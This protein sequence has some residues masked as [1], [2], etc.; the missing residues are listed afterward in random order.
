MWVEKVFRFTSLSLHVHCQTLSAGPA[1]SAD[2]RH[3]PYHAE[4]TLSSAQVLKVGECLGTQ[5]YPQT[6]TAHTA[7]VTWR[8]HLPLFLLRL[9]YF[10]CRINYCGAS[11]HFFF[12]ELHLHCAVR[13]QAFFPAMSSQT[14]CGGDTGGGGE[15]SEDGGGGGGSMTIEESSVVTPGLAGDGI[16]EGAAEGG[17]EGEAEGGV[18]GDGA[19]SS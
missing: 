8:V 7:L 3:T 19:S 15:G 13:L 10:T 12:D 6:L 2:L 9:N 11:L 5:I 14:R 17:G 18:C 16:G 4:S 1:W